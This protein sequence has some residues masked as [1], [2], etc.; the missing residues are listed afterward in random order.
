MSGII[1]MLVIP[2]EVSVILINGQQTAFSAYEKNHDSGMPE[3]LQLPICLLKVYLICYR[4]L[5]NRNIYP[6]S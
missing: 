1:Y 4:Y 3:G 5:D 6:R 2:T